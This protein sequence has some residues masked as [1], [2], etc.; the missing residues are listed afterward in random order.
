[1]IRAVSLG[2]AHSVATRPSAGRLGAR[3]SRPVGVPSIAVPLCQQNVATANSSDRPARR[4]SDAQRQHAESDQS[5]QNQVG[6]D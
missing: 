5:G 1:M 6:R 3:V 4:R 2:C